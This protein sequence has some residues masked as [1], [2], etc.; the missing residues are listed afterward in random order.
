MSV[1]AGRIADAGVDPEL[2]INKVA[3]LTKNLK[4]VEILW[5]SFRETFNIFQSE[6]SGCHIIT[7]EHSKFDKF[8]LIG[9]DLENYSKETVQ[10]FL[11][12]A[13]SSKFNNKKKIF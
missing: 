13:V 7:I 6:R 3:N 9:K 5:A 4:N 1:F 8:N 2:I 12:D 10:M 11:K